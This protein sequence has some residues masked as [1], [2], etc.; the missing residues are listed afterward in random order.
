VNGKSKEASKGMPGHI[1]HH[2]CLH[3]L[4]RPPPTQARSSND[5][6]VVRMDDA[7]ISNGFCRTRMLVLLVDDT[8]D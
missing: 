3:R 5:L 1:H 8:V 2:H 6:P 4:A 7:C